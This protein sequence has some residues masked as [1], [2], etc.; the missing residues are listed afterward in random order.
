MIITGQNEERVIA[1]SERLQCRG[2]VCDSGCQSAISLLGKQL[3]EENVR[4]NGLVLNAGIFLPELI[5]NMTPEVFNRTLDINI[6]GPFFTLSTL[7]PVMCNPASV[8][9]VSSI[10]VEKAFESC[11][12]YAA[13]KAAGEAFV[14]VA[15]KE[16]AE[17]GIRINTVRP[18]ISNTT[19]QEKAG[20]SQ[21]DKEVLLSSMNVTPL[22]RALNAVDHVAPVSFLLSDASI[23]MRNAVLQVDGG[24]CL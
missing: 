23:A 1:A 10:V 3:A 8:V 6:K 18:G 13:S 5:E 16:L 15:N 9:F 21:H 20:M 17:R 2:I 11:A 22:G 4:L 24:Y 19:I 12:I 14:R 7:L